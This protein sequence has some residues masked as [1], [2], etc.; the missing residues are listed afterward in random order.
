MAVVEGLPGEAFSVG[1]SVVRMG[2]VP[3][4]ELTLGEGCEAW[5]VLVLTDGTDV[6]G[7]ED[8]VASL[9]PKSAS[10]KLVAIAILRFFII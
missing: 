6:S 4:V 10:K 8:V 2:E 9:Q 1:D 5:G 3:T 7:V